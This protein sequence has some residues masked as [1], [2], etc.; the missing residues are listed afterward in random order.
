MVLFNK[1]QNVEI[2]IKIVIIERHV[3][4]LKCYLYQG[5]DMLMLDFAGVSDPF[6]IISLNNQSVRSDIIDNTVN[7]TW[8]QT[9]VI[10][11]IY[12][13]GDRNAIFE[14]PPEILVEIYDS[15][16]FKVTA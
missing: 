13:Y 3:F 4:E 11:D 6:A 9:L 10:N 16:P 14:D 15:D 2:L 7:P 8:N 1:T 12:L 5:R